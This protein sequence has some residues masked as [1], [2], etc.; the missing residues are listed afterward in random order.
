[1]LPLAVFLCLG[2]R[3]KQGC[4]VPGPSLRHSVQLGMVSLLLERAGSV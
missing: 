4:A 3:G 1:M 2:G